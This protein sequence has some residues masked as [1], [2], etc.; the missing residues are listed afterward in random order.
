[1]KVFGR[2]VR[3]IEN[4]TVIEGESETKTGRCSGGGGGG[5]RARAC[6]RVHVQ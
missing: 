5:A 1:M 2:R 4:K 6:M 3:W